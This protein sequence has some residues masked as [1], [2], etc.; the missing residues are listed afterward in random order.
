MH[1]N[2]F[3]QLVLK[4][5]YLVFL[6]LSLFVSHSHNVSATFYRIFNN[7]YIHTCLDTNSCRKL[8]ILLPHNQ[9][10]F[11]RN[12]F[13]SSFPLWV[14]F[15]GISR[16]GWIISVFVYNFLILVISFHFP[17]SNHWR[18]KS[19]NLVN[20]WAIFIKYSI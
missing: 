13:P 14:F 1:L 2:S 10:I 9:L 3:D 11:L 5:R 17:H 12:S 7:T 19:M 4:D 15:Q 20:H 6:K 18:N 8:L 16:S